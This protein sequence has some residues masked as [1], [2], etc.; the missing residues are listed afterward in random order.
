MHEKRTNLPDSPERLAA[1]EERGRFCEQNSPGEFVEDCYVLQPGSIMLQLYSRRNP[2]ELNDGWNIRVKLASESCPEGVWIHLPDYPFTKGDSPDEIGIALRRLGVEDVGACRIMDARCNVPGVGDIP[3]QY[4]SAEALLNDAN[5][6]GFIL[7]GKD[8]GAPDFEERFAAALEYENCSTLAEAVSIGNDVSSYGIVKVENLREFAGKELRHSGVPPKMRKDINLAEYGERLLLDRGYR[9]SRDGRLFVGRLDSAT[10]RNVRGLTP[11]KAEGVGAVSK[12]FDELLSLPHTEAQRIWLRMGLERLS[13]R[14]SAVLTALLSWKEPK[15]A[16]DVLN[17]LLNI[18]QCEVY[19]PVSNHAD[20][21]RRYLQEENVRLPDGAAEFTDMKKLG[22][23]CERKFPGQFVDDCY[24]LR[25]RYPL[26]EPYSGRNHM[27]DEGWNIRVK[28]ES[29]F[30]PE[31]AWIHFP[32]YSF[33]EGEMSGEIGI[34]LRWLGVE[35]MSECRIMDAQCDVPGVGD[36]PA[37]Y[38]SVEALLYDANNMGFLLEER[39]QGAFDFRE[40]FSAALKYENCSTLAEAVSIGENLSSY[41]IIKA[42]NLPEFARKELENS[43]VP[44]EIREAVNLEQYGRRLLL[45][46]GYRESQYW[47]L[48]V[49]RPDCAAERD[50]QRRTPKKKK[51]AEPTR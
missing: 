28:L 41:D 44:P 51:K 30:C 11:G 8:K 7:T 31:G 5:N 39:G 43:D 24:V 6:L 32:D 27:P 45:G 15:T 29:E 1:L 14:E 17:L 3:A 26:R 18:D 13:V 34:A 33:A 35:D 36:I 9:K 47:T 46:R 37:Q 4:D 42:E 16:T 12:G 10:E 50:A 21:G 48:F 2:E 25:P 40:T 23:I 22:H 19:S 20:L 49:G 38:D